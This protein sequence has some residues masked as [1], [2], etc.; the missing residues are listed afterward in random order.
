MIT[1]GQ[2]LKDGDYFIPETV[3]Q[4]VSISLCGHVGMNWYVKEFLQENFDNKYYPYYSQRF[5]MILSNSSELPFCKT[6][7]DFPDFKQLCENTF[8]T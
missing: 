8:T 6:E 2:K 5:E 4:L 1:Q 3:E 7:Y